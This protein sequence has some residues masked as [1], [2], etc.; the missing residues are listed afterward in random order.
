MGIPYK[1]HR[2]PLAVWRAAPCLGEDTDYVLREVLGYD[3]E[4]VAALR[5]AGTL[6]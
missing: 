4:H 5:D 3:E 6:S 1:L 2:T